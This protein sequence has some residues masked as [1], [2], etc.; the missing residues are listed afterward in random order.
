MEPVAQGNLQDYLEELNDSSK[1]MDA[2][3][4]TILRKWFGCLAS[5]LVYPHA[6]NIRYGNIQPSNILVKDSDIFLASF[7]VSKHFRGDDIVGGTIGGPDAQ[8][9][10]YVAPEV[11]FARPQ[12]FKADI[13]SLGCVYLDI[14]TIL[15]GKYQKGFAQ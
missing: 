6:K 11:E 5:G 15:A 7:G 1:W 13:F 10:T 8:L 4:Q 14:L 9:A 2:E 3:T 12:D